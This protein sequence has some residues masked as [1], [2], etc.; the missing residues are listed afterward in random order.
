MEMIQDVVVEIRFIIPEKKTAKGRSMS[1]KEYEA[2]MKQN[3]IAKWQLMNCSG[4]PV[5]I[6]YLASCR[7]SNFFSDKQK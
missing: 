1:Q 2:K 4:K 5:A 3:F 6:G 7:T